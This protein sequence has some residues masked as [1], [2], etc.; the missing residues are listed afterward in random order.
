MKELF[1]SCLALITNKY[2]V[3]ELATLIEGHQ[4]DVRPEK[5]V[6]HTGK[7]LKIGHELRIIANIGY[8]DMDYIIL[9]L[10]F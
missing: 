7:R 6:S 10:G 3:A 4:E 9:D 1:K 8:Y 2:V 5:R